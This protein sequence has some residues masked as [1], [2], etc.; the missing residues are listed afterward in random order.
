MVVV[1]V[2]VVAVVG[3]D[4]GTSLILGGQDSATIGRA[5][6]HSTPPRRTHPPHPWVASPWRWLSARGRSAR[7]SG[8]A[9]PA[10]RASACSAPWHPPCGCVHGLVTGH[11]RRTRFESFNERQAQ[12]AAAAAAAV[13][14]G[15]AATKL[16]PSRLASGS[17]R[18]LACLGVE[19]GA[20]VLYSSLNSNCTLPLGLLESPRPSVHKVQAIGWACRRL[21]P[22]SV[23]PLC[24]GRGPQTCRVHHWHRG[25][26]KLNVQRT[27]W[28]HSV[29][30]VAAAA[31]TVAV[32]GH[33]GGGRGGRCVYLPGASA[34]RYVQKRIHATEL[35]REL[36]EWPNAMGRRAAAAGGARRAA[37]CN[38]SSRTSHPLH[39]KRINAWYKCWDRL[40]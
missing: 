1:V 14:G 16:L 32:T 33:S 15:A 36:T 11:R 22:G 38:V 23:Q 37:Q 26:H 39:P 8:P 40:C 4:A 3:S 24:G 20:V 31:R 27:S 28:G 10:G 35:A 12:V 25:V 7:P 2:V 21:F 34:H 13:G 19:P 18:L 30:V 5:V 9:G 6:G 29:V 17:P